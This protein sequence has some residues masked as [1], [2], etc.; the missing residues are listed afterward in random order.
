MDYL[1]NSS[2]SLARPVKAVPGTQFCS[3]DEGFTLINVADDQLSF[4]LINDRG[5]VI[6]SYRRSL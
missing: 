4:H 5:E 2:G 1:V 3:S 6:Y